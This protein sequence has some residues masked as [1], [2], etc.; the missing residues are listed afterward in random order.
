MR[1]VKYPSTVHLPWAE[2]VTTDDKIIESVDGFCGQRVIVTEKMDGENTSMYH[3]KIHARSLDSVNH[4]SRNWVK[5]FWGGIR[6]N[7]PHDIRICGEN[8]F[9]KHSI[10]YT[11]LSSYFLG[12]NAWRENTCLAWDETLELFNIIGIT[13]VPILYDGLFDEDK[14]RNISLDMNRQEGYVMRVAD[15]FFI[16]DFEKCVAKFVREGHV[17]TDKHWMRGPIIPNILR[18][19]TV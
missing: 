1:Y 2:R 3:N 14:I 8:C 5:N 19:I 11:N 4:P 10:H 9:A 17:Q 7:I 6:H 15:E 13:P 12:F 16:D 18:E